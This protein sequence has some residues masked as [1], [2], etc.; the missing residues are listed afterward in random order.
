MEKEFKQAPSL[1]STSSYLSM[2]FCFLFSVWAP[3]G[4]DRSRKFAGFVRSSL[5]A[6]THGT[7]HGNYIYKHACGHHWK[8]VPD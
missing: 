4:F 3:I 8:K 7:V 2:N 6:E 5:C 1:F